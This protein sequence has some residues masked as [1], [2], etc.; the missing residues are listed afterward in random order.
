MWY[1]SYAKQQNKSIVTLCESV[2]VWGPHSHLQILVFICWIIWWLFGITRKSYFYPVIIYV[3]YVIS[4]PTLHSAPFFIFNYLMVEIKYWTPWFIMKLFI[5]F[6]T[7]LL[8]LLR[9]SVSGDK[10][11]S[12]LLAESSQC[13]FLNKFWGLLMLWGR[14]CLFREGERE[15]DIL[16]QL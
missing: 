8:N 6:V 13:H 12:P 9:P 16:V 2:T 5:L 10:A 14:C 15:A 11:C 4:F 1:R 7:L 3:T